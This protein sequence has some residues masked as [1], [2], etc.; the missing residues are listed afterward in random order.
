MTAWSVKGLSRYPCWCSWKNSNKCPVFVE[1]ALNKRNNIENK[2]V[3][4]CTNTQLRFVITSVC[5]KKCFS[6]QHDLNVMNK[7][8]SVFLLVINV[9]K[10]KLFFAGSSLLT[11]LRVLF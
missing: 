1:A 2:S 5:I 11:S 10:Q 6:Y 7:K 3:V 9:F 8:L 4:S